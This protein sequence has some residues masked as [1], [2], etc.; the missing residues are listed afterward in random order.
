VPVA[1]RPARRAA[2]VGRRLQLGLHGTRAESENYEQSTKTHDDPFA[3]ANRSTV[4]V[5]V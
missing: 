4:Q 5:G 2:H 3:T 1:L